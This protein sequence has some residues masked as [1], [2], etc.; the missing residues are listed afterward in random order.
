[1]ISLIMVLGLLGE[2]GVGYAQEPAGSKP[3]K[4]GTVNQAKIEAKWLEYGVLKKQFEEIL[5]VDRRDIGKIRNNIESRRTKVEED[6]KQKKLK[7]EEYHNLRR[8]LAIQ[9][10]RLEVYAEVRAGIVQDKVEQ[11]LQKASK[12]VD[13]VIAEIA[14]KEGYDLIINDNE[15]MGVDPGLDISDKVISALESKHYGL[16]GF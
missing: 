10:Q 9:M 16:V 1:M 2:T 11:Q 5:K 15:L 8:A 12:I 13:D 6:Y 14:Q 7:D 3:Q 4:V